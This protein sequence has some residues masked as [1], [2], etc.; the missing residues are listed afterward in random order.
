MVV[1]F[2]TTTQTHLLHYYHY[3]HCQ[4]YVH[5]STRHRHHHHL[6]LLANNEVVDVLSSV[7]N[8]GNHFVP[9]LKKN[10]V[11]CLKKGVEYWKVANSWNPFWGES[12]FFRIKR[13]VDE[14]GIEDNV[15][16]NSP[17]SKWGPKQ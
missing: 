13:G 10:F 5:F 1:Y 9:C 14:C 15:M 11:S 6:L 4:F 2:I 12:G 17:D 16:A 3:L 8:S 7:Q